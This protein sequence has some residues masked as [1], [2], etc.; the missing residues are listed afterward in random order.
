MM[1]LVKLFRSHPV[2]QTS[3]Y[4]TPLLDILKRKRRLLSISAFLL[5]LSFTYGIV[6]NALCM[7]LTFRLRSVVDFFNNF[8]CMLVTLILIYKSNCFSHTVIASFSI[9]KNRL[10]RINVCLRIGKSLTI[11]CHP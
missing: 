3:D 8:H 7:L 5:W 9:F 11:M 1:D 2:S 4:L 6:A 10:Y